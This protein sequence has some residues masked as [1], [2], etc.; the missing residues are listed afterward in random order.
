MLHCGE[1]PSF[2]VNFLPEP[3]HAVQVFSSSRQSKIPPARSLDFNQNKTLGEASETRNNM[4]V[5]ATT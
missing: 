1:F 3:V 4:D 5:R 2:E